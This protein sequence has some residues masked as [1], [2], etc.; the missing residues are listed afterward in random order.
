MQTD[1]AVQATD[2]NDMLNL[3][4]HRHTHTEWKAKVA[5]SCVVCASTCVN[6]SFSLCVWSRAVDGRRLRSR[7]MLSIHSPLQLLLPQSLSFFL[8]LSSIHLVTRSTV[9]ATSG[10]HARTHVG[11]LLQRRLLIKGRI[12]RAAHTEWSHICVCVCNM[13]ELA[14]QPFTKR[15]THTESVR[16]TV[17]VEVERSRRIGQELERLK[18]QQQQQEP[19]KRE[20][21]SWV[22][23]YNNLQR[24]QC[25]RLHLSVCVCVWAG[26][27]RDSHRGKVQLSAG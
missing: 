7:R 21:A 18:Q 19:I 9:L 26:K 15:H 12:K 27:V 14:V 25:T 2:A 8:S 16:W 17:E 6:E 4:S 5:S 11:F 24:E 1:S 23:R 20:R 22:V 3:F 13:F 10:G